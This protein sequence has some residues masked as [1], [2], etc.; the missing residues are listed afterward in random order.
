MPDF[1][2]IVDDNHTPVRL[3]RYVSE[4]LC[5]FSRSQ[6]KVRSLKVKLNGKEVKLSRPVK[7]GDHL[8]LNWDDPPP[9]DIIPQEIPLE[10][11]WED[12][13]CIV[14]NK[15]QGMVVHPGAGNRQNTL[16]NALCF[17]RKEVWNK[18]NLIQA[19]KTR[20]GIVHRLD[21]ETSG[22]IICAWDEEAHAFLAE[23][24]KTRNVSKNYIAIVCG[25]PKE[26]K[27]R[28][29]TFITR[30][31]KNR[32]RFSVSDKGRHAVTIYKVIK[33]WQNY[34]L[35]HLRPKTGRTHQLRVH[36]RFIG[37]PILGDTVYGCSDKKFPNV[38]MMLHSKSLKII[39][40]GEK[41]A[42][43][44]SSEMPERFNDV[45]EKLNKAEALN[46]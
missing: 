2:H 40:P 7:Q 21:K 44:F 37:N 14:I 17:R 45:I 6:I 31:P 29:E 41:Q 22:I 24:F 13:K 5:L 30:D 28:I 8:E 32:K 4:V 18:N 16:V 38:N 26:K 23:Q 27:G 1:S 3:D 9:L 20:P 46:G 12:D 43:F 34:S 15:A 42:R 11:V 10:V 36:M 35:L 25:I 33:Q 19:D 39:L